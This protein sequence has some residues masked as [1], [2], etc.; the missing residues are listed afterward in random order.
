MSSKF[1]GNSKVKGQSD[2]NQKNKTKPGS[3]NKA[4]T[5]VRKTG[6]GS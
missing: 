1:F 2:K 6:R 4:T 5:A 3:K